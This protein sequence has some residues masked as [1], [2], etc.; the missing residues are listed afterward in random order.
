MDGYFD[1]RDLIPDGS[2]VEIGFH[3]LENSPVATIR[4]IYEQL[5]LLDFETTRQA[6]T[7]YLE[8]IRD[9]Q[10]NTN[11]ELSS[12]TKEMLK[13]EWSRS[14]AEWDYSP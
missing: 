3:Q 7:A 11:A 6:V 12:Q 5:S 13:R 1:N 10:K 14:F 9:Y 4:H 2:L 8:T